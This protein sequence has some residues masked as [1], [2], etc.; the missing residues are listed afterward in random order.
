MSTLELIGEG[1][2]DWDLIKLHMQ[3]SVFATAC[4]QVG[5]ELR[6]SKAKS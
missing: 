2:G 5:L 1:R 4:G 6:F 3:V